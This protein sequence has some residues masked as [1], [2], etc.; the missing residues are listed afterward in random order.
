VIYYSVNYERLKE[1]N[2]LIE[3]M[4]QQASAR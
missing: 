2:N 3:E 4:L 1:L